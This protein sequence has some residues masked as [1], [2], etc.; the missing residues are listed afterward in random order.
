MDDFSIIND[1]HSRQLIIVDRFGKPVRVLFGYEPDYKQLYEL[2][3]I[4]QERIFNNNNREEE[5]K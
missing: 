4:Q 5:H 1:P 3:Q 2:W